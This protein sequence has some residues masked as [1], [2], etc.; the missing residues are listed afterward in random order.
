MSI[1][2]LDAFGLMRSAL[3]AISQIESVF[4]LPPI[5]SASC[6]SK[7]KAAGPTSFLWLVHC[8][9]ATMFFPCPVH[10]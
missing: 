8:D 7:P 2:L 5:R 10:I 9:L 4:V 3:Y 1:G 6:A